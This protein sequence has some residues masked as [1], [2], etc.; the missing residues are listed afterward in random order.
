MN[1]TLAHQL[2]TY[3]GNDQLPEAIAHAETELSALPTSAFH[4]ILQ[5]DLLHL[6]EELTQYLTKADIF[7][8]VHLGSSKEF[9][10]MPAAQKLSLRPGAY[11]CA[12]NGFTINYDRWFLNLFSFKSMGPTDDW[13]WLSDYYF[14]HEDFTLHGWEE[15]QTAFQ[16]AQETRLH[17]NKEA[18]AAFEV[19]ELL[20]ILRLQELFQHVFATSETRWKNIPTLVGAHDYHSLVFP[21]N[22]LQ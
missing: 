18:Y 15:L 4:W 6:T 5:K 7:A 22:P 14:G 17:K 19:C 13:D 12:L 1:F 21:I 3:L 2:Q 9:A 11:Y 8:R 10:G 20:V 16:I